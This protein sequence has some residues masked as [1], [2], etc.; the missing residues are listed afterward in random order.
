MSVA[1][2]GMLTVAYA[3]NDM[4]LMFLRMALDAH[5]IEYLVVGEHFGN[6][7]PGPQIADYNERSIRVAPK[8]VAH[9][10]DI[11]QHVRERFDSGSTQQ[12]LLARLRMIAEALVFGWFMPGG[13]R[14]D[15]S[16]EEGAANADDTQGE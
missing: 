5:G 4:E 3:D 14:R 15:A 12:S 10:I 13:R 7:Y 16:A 6:L 9:A 1:R 2:A 11:I 8:D